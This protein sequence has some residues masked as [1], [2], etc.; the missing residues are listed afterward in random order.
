M[1]W[2][3]SQSRAATPPVRQDMEMMLRVVGDCANHSL[4]LGRISSP[5][6]IET[7]AFCE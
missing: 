7:C 3:V 5:V 1:G 6:N 4:N 2:L